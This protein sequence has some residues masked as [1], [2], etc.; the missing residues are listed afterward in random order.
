M[1]PYGAG[2]CQHQFHLDVEP[3]K[4]TTRRES[5]QRK[6][7]LE[8]KVIMPA[9]SCKPRWIFRGRAVL[10]TLGEIYQ[11]MPARTATSSEQELCTGVVPCKEQ[12][13]NLEGMWKALR[14]H[15][16]YWQG[17]TEINSGKL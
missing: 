4:D 3:S 15:Q 2:D 7:R 12:K 9:L 16:L 17:D 11:A 10:G 6:T 13:R 5:H 14:T 8:G 1:D